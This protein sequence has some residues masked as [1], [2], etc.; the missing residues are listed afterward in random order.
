[1]LSPI[2]AILP[3]EMYSSPF[4]SKDLKRAPWFAARRDRPTG[5]AGYLERDRPTGS[6]V[7]SRRV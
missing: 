3:E 4:H 5:V 2:F 6:V 7:L 1:M